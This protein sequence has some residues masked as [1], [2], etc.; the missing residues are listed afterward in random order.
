MSDQLTLLFASLADPTRQRI[1][2]ELA[3][4][5]RTV[6]E[7]VELFDLGQPTVSKHLKVLESAGL[8][9]KRVEG[10]RRICRL[11]GAALQSIEHWASRHRANWE[12]RVDN[13][14]AY[15]KGRKRRS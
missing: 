13:L 12:A 6:S 14:D 3:S 10:N 5:E 7:L 15:L 11:D 4:G 8:V 1:V 2:G 9:R